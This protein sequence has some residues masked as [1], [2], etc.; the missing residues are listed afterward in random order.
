M[1]DHPWY[2]L[3]CLAQHELS[4][5][6]KIQDLKYDAMAPW[7]EAQ[8]RVRGCQ[9]PWRF[10]LYT[11]YVFVQLADPDAGWQHLK[12]QFNSPERWLIFKLLSETPEAPPTALRPTDVAH[13]M[14]IRDGKYSV[15]AE[16]RELVVGDCV[17]VPEGY[18]Q[19]QFQGQTSIVSRIN[20]G[21][22][23]TLTL[24][25]DE[26]VKITDVPVANLVKV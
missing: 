12:A 3:S 9:R 26:R 22:K 10:P 19:D 24:K 4:L 16:C 15:E 2:V 11:G 21:N 25:R 5:E 17:L 7:D 13:L 8:K 14:S 20:S 23:A 6:K 18:L 1:S